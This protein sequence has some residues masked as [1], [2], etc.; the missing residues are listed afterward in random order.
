MKVSFFI[1]Q[2]SATFLELDIENEHSVTTCCEVILSGIFLTQTTRV[3]H[4][5]S[6]DP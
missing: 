1:P 4:A 5:L 3:A 2:E 6:Q